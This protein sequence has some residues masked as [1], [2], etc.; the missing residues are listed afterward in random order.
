MKTMTLKNKDR[1]RVLGQLYELIEDDGSES[2]FILLS[3]QTFYDPFDEM[4]KATIN[5]YE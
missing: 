3:M 2:D 5:Y 4:W 1:S